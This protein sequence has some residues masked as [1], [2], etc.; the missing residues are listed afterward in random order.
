MPRIFN[1]VGL[2]AVVAVAAVAGTAGAAAPA[3]A[4][5]IAQNVTSAPRALGPGLVPAD[6]EDFRFDLYDADLYLSRDESGRSRLTTVETLVPEFPEFD[7]NR[8][9][10][11]AIPNDYDSVRLDTRVESVTDENGSPVPYEIDTEDGFTLVS[12]G[13]DDYLHGRHTFV[14]TYQQ[15]DVVRSFSDT[16]ADELYWDINGTGWAQPFAEVAARI[17]VDPELVPELTGNTACYAGPARDSNACEI[18]AASG[19]GGERVFSST[20]GPLWAGQTLTM[21]IGFQPGTFVP[22][23]QLNR[24][25]WVSTAPIILVILLI[26]G[27]IALAVRRAVL[28]RNAPGRGIVVP[29]YTAPEGIDLLVASDIIGQTGR[30]VPATFISFA[31]RKIM[32][33]LTYAP[34]GTDAKNMVYTFQFLG[35]SDHVSKL[36]RKILVALF[37]AKA[38]PGKLKPLRKNDAAL[39]ASFGEIRKDIPG[40]SIAQG[41]RYKPQGSLGRWLVVPLFMLQLVCL[42]WSLF[43]PAFLTGTIWTGIL[44]VASI[45]SFVATLFIVSKP[46]LLTAKGAQMREYLE[47]MR[48]YM[49]LAE[50]ERFRVLQSPG[51]AERVDVGDNYQLVKLYE[52]LLPFAVLWGIEREWSKELSERYAQLDQRPDW[53]VSEDGFSSAVFVTTMSRFSVQA[54]TVTLPPSASGSSSGSFSGGSMGGG[55]AGG[56]GGGGGGGGR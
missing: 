23:V 15:R 52:K 7:Q 56:G 50:Q 30:A 1:V 24:S 36:E 37:G 55:F 43:A 3:S 17:H 11:R 9:I 28:W 14:I 40:Q 46:S 34:A 4:S 5:E 12:I 13:T 27:V 32:R 26:L 54:N 38:G 6:V 47:G 18:E 49:R 20:V 48:D 41:Y 29:Q 2:S 10:I 53:F 22:G 8:G 39:G 42:L 51:G 35:W 44:L 45:V 21:A 16:R 25:P 33:I 19:A 31:V